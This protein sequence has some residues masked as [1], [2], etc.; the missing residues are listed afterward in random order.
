MRETRSSGSVEGAM[1]NHDS[2]SDSSRIRL[3]NIFKM[4]ARAAISAPTHSPCHRD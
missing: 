2:Y 4:P 1:G 3:I